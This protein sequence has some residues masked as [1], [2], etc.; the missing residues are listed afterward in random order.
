M[1]HLCLSMSCLHLNALSHTHTILIWLICLCH[2][3]IVLNSV[4][5]T[6]PPSPLILAPLASVTSSKSCPETSPTNPVLCQLIPPTLTNAKLLWVLHNTIIPS[7]LCFMHRAAVRQ[8]TKEYLLGPACGHSFSARWPSHS[9]SLQLY[10]L[11]TPPSQTGRPP[12]LCWWTQFLTT[13]TA[14]ISNHD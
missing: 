12:G 10:L 5:H 1:A 3:F 13:S 6:C 14:S 4:F 7:Y 2:A 8:P 11:K 9:V